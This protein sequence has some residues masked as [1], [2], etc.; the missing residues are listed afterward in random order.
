MAVANLAIMSAIRYSGLRQVIAMP[1]LGSAILTG[2][3]LELGAF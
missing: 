1:L 2:A 3:Y